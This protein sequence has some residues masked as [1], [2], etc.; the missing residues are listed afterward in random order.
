MEIKLDYKTMHSIAKELNFPAT[1]FVETKNINEVHKIKYFTIPGEISACGHA[2]WATAKVIFELTAKYSAKFK[3]IEN[4]VIDTNLNE[5]IILMTYPKYET[6]TIDI[7]ENILKSLGVNNYK[8]VE[9]CK[10]LQTL[11]IELESPQILRELQPNYKILTESTNQIK[12]VVVTSVS[13]NENYDFILRSFCPWI[14]IDEDPVTGSV[15][16]VLANFWKD[17]L[18]KTE[19]TAYQ[20]S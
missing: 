13:D 8:S 6:V 17:R 9:F 5:N 12:E 11:I 16:S 1:A 2:T 19:L 3:T 10:E 18:N 15:H 14:G 4:I 20:A 7:S